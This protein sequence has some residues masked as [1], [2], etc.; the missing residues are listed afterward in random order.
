M[1]LK[2]DCPRRE[3]SEAVSMAQIATSARSPQI[4]LQNLKIE[5][6]DGGIRVV[7][8]DGEM[9]IERDMA[10]MVHEGGSTLVQ[11]KFLSDLIGS[12]PDG[13]LQ[14]ELTDTM[15]V[16]LT[17]GASE[18]LV[19]SIDAG[20]F[21]EPPDYGGE[22]ELTIA[23][24]ILREAID[25]VVY[26][27]SQDLHRPA[28]TGVQFLYDGETLTLVATDTH[29][30]AVRRI[31]QAGLGNN[32]TAVVPGRALEAI[33]RLPLTDDQ[34][35][36][37]RFGVGRVGV[38][39]GG[40]KIVAQLITGAYPNWERV[41]PTEWTRLW[42]C[43]IDQLKERV[44]RTMIIAR[45]SAN[46]VRFKGDGDQIILAARSE[47]K[48]EAKEEVPMVATNGEI[49]IAFNGKYVEDSL[50]AMPG[51]GVRVEMTEYTRAAVFRPADDPNS[52]FCVIMPMALA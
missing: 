48:G 45:D 15:G 25:S 40:A 9:W 4:I 42:T 12:L 36:N 31:S 39:A 7:G 6:K 37:I 49:E 2:L 24:G 34:T 1:P 23:M 47:E 46:R 44:N 33:K 22:G 21:P 18:Y 27:C 35:I 52:Y 8:C 41:V 43:E 38:D 20:N 50:K 13:D 11:A 26:A 51:T 30:L 17:Q 28:L 3:F 5:A 10:C 16:K 29:R 14:L 19:K 32:I